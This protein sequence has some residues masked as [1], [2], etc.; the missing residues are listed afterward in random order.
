[1]TRLPPKLRALLLAVA[2]VGGL[3]VP[4]GF[5]VQRARDGRDYASFHYAAQLWADGGDP[6]DSDALTRAAR[7]DGRKGTVY[8]FFYP[9]PALPL[10]AWTLP[11]SLQ[12][13]HR[14]MA[15]MNVGALLGLGFVLARWLKAP[16]WLPLL[17]LACSS[18]A[19][20]TARLGQVNGVLALLVGL[21]AWR[22]RG[23]PIAVA[24]LLK[25]SPAVLLVR[26][27]AARRWRALFMGVGVGVG[28]LAA[29]LL[30]VDIALFRRFFVEILPGLSDGG[31]NGLGVPLSFR[32]NHSLPG[33][34]DGLFPGPDD[35]TLSG[36][37]RTLAGGAT[38]VGI[39][40]LG[41]LGRVERDPLGEALLWGALSALIV[42]TPVYAWEHHHVLLLLPMVAV[43]TALLRGRLPKWAWVVFGLCWAIW[44]WRLPWWRAAWR[45]LAPL[46]PLIEES[47]LLLPLLLLG[48][49]A[50]GAARSPAAPVRSA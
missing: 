3:L 36:T 39:A 43:G 11:L 16:L 22:A 28:G 32:A 26:F 12:W 1:V 15:L 14:L 49:G 9:P 10:F 42:I 27:L 44:A 19:V 24:A 46:R 25:M 45:T 17:L 35:A 23:A 6:Y 20:E 50:W 29:S 33:L 8:P 34:L 2:L 7:Q 13:G 21:G 40:G 38:L 30:V 5:A 47:K 37:A 31:W 48:L 41:W 18:G 4:A